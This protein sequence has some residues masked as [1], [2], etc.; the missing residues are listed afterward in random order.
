MDNTGYK[1][2]VHVSHIA[3][4]LRYIQPALLVVDN[5]GYKALV[6]VGHIAT[7]LR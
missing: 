7:R 6:H 1:A 3:T 2:L 5:T 4:R